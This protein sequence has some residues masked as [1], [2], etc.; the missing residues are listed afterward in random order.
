MWYKICG[1]TIDYRYPVNYK[2]T[3]DAGKITIQ[4]IM[5]TYPKPYYIMCSGGLDSQAMLY[6]WKLFGNNYIPTT[7]IYNN[8]LNYHDIKTIYEFGKINNI[9][10]NS[11]Y[12]DILNFYENDF[13]NFCEQTKCISAHF[14]AHLEM[15]KNLEG[16][17]IFGG[18][19][20]IAKTSVMTKAMLCLYEASK[21]RN[22]VP[23][24]WAETPEI[25]YSFDYEFY[26]LKKYKSRFFNLVMTEARSYI[27]HQEGIPVIPQQKKYTGFEIIKDYY[28]ENFSYRV[29]PEM[30]KKLTHKYL[31]D[32]TYDLLL[33]YPYEEKF[34][35]NGLLTCFSNSY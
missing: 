10:I 11:L 5:D 35:T 3:L 30:R 16:T 15:T 25:L 17:V 34:G 9:E 33:R 29:S 4:N 8:N 32:R 23:F 21:T 7:V 2:P 6:L 19:R 18:D 13:A 22:L 20:L 1:D 26:I 28:D 14:A 31:S 12:F 27:F 24:F